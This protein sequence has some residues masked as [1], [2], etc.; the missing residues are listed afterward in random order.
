MLRSK[1][2]ADCH[3][4]TDIWFLILLEWL[5]KKVRSDSQV[6]ERDEYITS[7]V[8]KNMNKIVLQIPYLIIYENIAPPPQ[9]N[10]QKIALRFMREF[11]VSIY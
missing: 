11:V 6:L 2:N 3:P 8:Q 5:L 10:V 7:H 4:P 9:E 1:I